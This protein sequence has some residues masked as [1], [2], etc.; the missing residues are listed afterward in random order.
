MHKLIKEINF[1][2]LEINSSYLKMVK[3]V[4]TLPVIIFTVNARGGSAFFHSLLDGNNQIINLPEIRSIWD[5]I[6]HSNYISSELIADRFIAR[7]PQIFNSSLNVIEGWDSLGEKNNNFVKVDIN[8]FKKHFSSLYEYVEKDEKNIFLIIHIAYCLTCNYDPLK[9]KVLFYH[10]HKPRK[11]CEPYIP[12]GLKYKLLHITRDPRIGL[13]RY[14]ESVRLDKSSWDINGEYQMGNELYRSPTRLFANFKSIITQVQIYK[15][16]RNLLRIFTLEDLH[17]QR[18]DLLNKIFKNYNLEELKEEPRS[19]FWKF[20][21]YSDI[22]STDSVSGFQTGK[23]N[24]K[25]S[26]YLNFMDVFLIE[27][28][29]YKRSNI[30]NHSTNLKLSDFLYKLL[31]PLMF[32]IVICPLSYEFKNIIDALRKKRF[33]YFLL[34]IY[35]YLKRVIFCWSWLFLIISNNVFYPNQIK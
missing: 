17:E 32:L 35:I 29:T 27:Y 20:Q 7:N 19:T 8:V 31:W 14:Q 4:K 3:H 10:L 21:W 6:N 24:F 28:L 22:K 33:F 11:I 13:V 18:L 16:Q 25:Y 26:K 5:Y 30:Q 34:N 15:N 23:R 1:N 9:G 12:S 2:N